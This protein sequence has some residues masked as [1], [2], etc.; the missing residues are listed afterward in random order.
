MSDTTATTMR[1]SSY[2][3]QRLDPPRSG[4]DALRLDNPFAFGGGYKN[5]GLSDE[6]MD[7]LRDIFAFDYMGAAEF[8]FGEVPKALQGIAACADADSLEAFEFTILNSKIVKPWRGEASP[9]APRS[10][11]TVYV[12]APE[13]WHDEVVERVTALTGKNPPRTKEWVG[14]AEVLRPDSEW[15]RRTRGWLE[16]DNGYFF[17]TDREMWV[18][19]ARLFG[20]EVD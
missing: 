18:N 1:R 12:I 19:T 2:L 14:L 13:A 10:R 11:S 9:P 5:G 17:F 8:E 16:I 6:A 4:T 20:V 7:L 15:Q 3:I